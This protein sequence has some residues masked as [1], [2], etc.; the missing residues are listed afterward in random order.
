MRLGFEG[1]DL[2]SEFVALLR[3]G[4]RV[5][6]YAV[7]FDAEQ[8]FGDRQ[9]QVAVEAFQLRFGRELR[10]QYLMHAQRDIGILGG[11]FGGARDID[12]GEGNARGT[13]AGDG[14]VADRGQTAVARREGAE[15]MRLV[16]FQYIGLQQ[17]VLDDAAQA[18][19]V[20]G[21]D[22]AVVLEVLPQLAV[23]RRFEPGFQLRQGLGQ[24]QLRRCAGIAV[25]QRQ[26]GGAHIGT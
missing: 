4:R 2:A 6:Q 21:E 12:L 26:V 1:H 11:V 10:P 7:A 19:A 16:G 18:Q 23:L 22:V 20:V 17:R 5:D 15:V 8:H 9:F 24:R 3:E 13:L 14:V 25:A